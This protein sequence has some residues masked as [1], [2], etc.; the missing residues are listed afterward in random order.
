LKELYDSVKKSPLTMES[1]RRLDWNAE[2]TLEFGEFQITKWYWD[3][4]DGKSKKL[5]M[6]HRKN[7]AKFKEL[8][9]LLAPISQKTKG[10]LLDYTL[11]Y[12]HP[13]EVLI[14]HQIAVLRKTDTFACAF[15]GV[16]GRYRNELDLKK[17]LDLNSKNIWLA[18]LM[19]RGV[20]QIAQLDGDI[21][22]LDEVR[23]FL[24]KHEHVKIRYQTGLKRS[25][26][27]ITSSKPNP[28]R[29]ETNPDEN[30]V[31]NEESEC[32]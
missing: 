22:T 10:Q 16:W 12:W 19:L 5:Y 17:P 30:V 9:V 24:A 26:T 8:A 11:S 21:I 25:H 1:V 23:K 7:D 28:R 27:G 14:E 18:N 29:H 15:T 13:L 2:N 4:E 3:L 31:I 6:F 32:F 20:R